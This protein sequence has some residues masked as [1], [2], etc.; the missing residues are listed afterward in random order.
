MKSVS[1]ATVSS[2]SSVKYF[3]IKATHYYCGDG[4][5]NYTL[6]EQCEGLDLNSQTC[7][8]QGRGEGDLSCSAFCTFDVSDCEISLPPT[9]PGDDIPDIPSIPG[10][11]SS[12]GSSTSN[13]TVG[14]KDQCY[15]GMPERVCV[16][17]TSYKFR[18]CGNFDSDSCTE[19]GKYIT[20]PCGA[21]EKCY[22]GFCVPP[23]SKKNV[24][25]CNNLGYQCGNYIEDGVEFNCGTCNDGY[26]CIRGSCIEEKKEF[27]LTVYDW[28][29]INLD[30][31]NLWRLF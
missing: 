31:R 18:D 29:M 1:S 11:S 2:T 24:N 22:A 28:L 26:N 10:G 25:L 12:G 20:V 16:D 13:A 19:L 30:L 21:D 15:F 7:E 17:L 6:F 27:K 23:V 8:S 5:I 9:P 4:I 14:C 3:K